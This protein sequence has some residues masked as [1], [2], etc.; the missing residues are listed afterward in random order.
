MRASRIKY[1]LA[2]EPTADLVAVHKAATKISLQD[3][4]V[5]SP[6]HSTPARSF[7]KEKGVKVPPAK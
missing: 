7:F 1:R 6:L 2:L 5:G 4:V 3:A